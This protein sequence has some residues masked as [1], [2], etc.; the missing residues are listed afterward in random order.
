MHCGGPTQI[1]RVTYGL[2]TAHAAT[3]RL[4]LPYIC[5]KHGD[6]NNSHCEHN[7]SLL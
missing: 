4:S 5:I 6:I 3:R 1:L 7:R 2:R